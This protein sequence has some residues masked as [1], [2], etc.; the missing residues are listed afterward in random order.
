MRS[1]IA[2]ATLTL[3]VACAGSEAVTVEG[4]VVGVDGDLTT[5][6]S[7]ELLTTNGETITLVPAPFGDF[8]FPLP[9]LSAHMRSLEPVRVT[10]STSEDGMHLADGIADATQ[11]ETP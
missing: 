6:R 4:V 5:V 2:V 11:G 8:E 1:A 7:F 9:H 10:Y 3:V